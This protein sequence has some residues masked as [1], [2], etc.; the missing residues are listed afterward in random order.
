MKGPLKPRNDNAIFECRVLSRNHAQIWYQ[1]DHFFLKDMGSSNGT[2]VNGQK[3]NDK[4]K[5]SEFYLIL[6]QMQDKE[7]TRVMIHG[8]CM[9]FMNFSQPPLFFYVLPVFDVFLLQ[10]VFGISSFLV[11]F[12]WHLNGYV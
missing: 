3:I 1:D 7:I 12:R 6:K 8:K 4:E 9:I 2:F 5:Q 10:S 11:S